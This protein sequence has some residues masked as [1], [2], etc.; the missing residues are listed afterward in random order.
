V[1]PPS[2]RTEEETEFLRDVLRDFLRDVLR[3]FLRDVLCDFLRDVLRDF[4]RDVLRGFSACSVSPSSLYRRVC[5]ISKSVYRFVM[6]VCPHGTTRLPLDEFSLDFIFEYFS[7]V[8]RENSSFI[9]IGQ[10][11]RGTLHEDQFTF[12]V[13][14]RSVLL[15]MGNVS[16]ISCR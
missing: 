16:D 11:E 12:L 13:I 15:R 10:E 5:K 4:L 3:D 14:S 2:P 6:S 8:C 1:L 9:K 7:N